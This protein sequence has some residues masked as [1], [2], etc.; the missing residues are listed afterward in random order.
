MTKSY[1]HDAAAMPLVAAHYELDKL[2]Y[3]D[4]T[5]RVLS[6]YEEVEALFPETEVLE[7][8]GADIHIILA[9]LTDG[10]LDAIDFGA[11]L[12]DGLNVALFSEAV[13]NGF[14]PACLP[15]L[16]DDFSAAEVNGQLSHFVDAAVMQALPSFDW[17]E[18]RLAE[19][20]IVL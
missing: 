3:F 2:R 15:D 17:L 6:K 1:K 5:D 20:G 9:A 13:A 10:G 11:A 14:D 18:A 8:Q 16:M 19:F 4:D 7:A 12:D